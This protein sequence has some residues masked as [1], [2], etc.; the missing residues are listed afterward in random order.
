M[1]DDNNWGHNADAQLNV[2]LTLIV[3]KDEEKNSKDKQIRGLKQ[4]INLPKN[5]QILATDW[6]VEPC[7]IT[8]GTMKII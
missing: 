6:E 7:V 8:M 4:T 3:P 1:M 2:Q 5:E